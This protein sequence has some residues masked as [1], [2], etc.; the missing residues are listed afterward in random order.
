[1]YRWNRGCYGITDGKPH[2]R[3][4]NRVLPSGPSVVD[5]VA[6]AAFYFGLMRALGEAPRRHRDDDFDEAGTT[7]SAARHGLGAQFTWLDGTRCAES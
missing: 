4:E 1:M 6:N 2:L 3:I 7:S 5:E